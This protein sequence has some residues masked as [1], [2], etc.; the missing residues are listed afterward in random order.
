MSD[1]NFTV[2]ANGWVCVKHAKRDYPVE[3]L[4]PSGVFS[5]Y[6]VRNPN[7]GSCQEVKTCKNGCVFIDK[8]G[9]YQVTIPDAATAGVC[10]GMAM[11]VDIEYIEGAGAPPIEVTPDAAF[12]DLFVSLGDTIVAAIEAQTATL[13]ADLQAICDKLEAGITVNAVQSGEWVVSID[14][15]PLSVELTADNIADLAAALEGLT[16]TIGGQDVTLDVNIVNDTLTVALDADSLAALENITVTID[17]SAGPVEITGEVT[18][19]TGDNG[20]AID[21]TGIKDALTGLVVEAEINNFS[22]LVALLTADDVTITVDGT[23]AIEQDQI[24]SLL[25][26]LT[27]IEDAIKNTVRVDWEPLN[28]CVVDAEGNSVPLTGVFDEIRYDSAGVV[29]SRTLVLSQLAADGSAWSSYT[30]GAGETVAE[31]PKMKTK[32]DCVESQEWTY[33]GDNTGTDFSDTATYVMNLSDGSTL[34]VVQTPTNGWTEQNQL[35]TT[36]WQAEADAAGLA[37]FIEPRA[38]NNAIPTDISGGYGANSVPTGLPGAPSIPVAEYLIKNGIVARYLNFQICPGQPVPVSIV[39]TTSALGLPT[40]YKLTTA[41]AIKGPLQR[42]FVCRDCGEKPIWFLKD[43]VTPASAGQ[44]P[45]CYEPCGVISQLPAPPE[46]D[47]KFEISIG[48]DNNNSTNTVDFT[49]TIT[50]RATICNGNTIAVDYFQADPNDQS[51][52][53]AYTLV[54]DFVDCATGDA[55]P[56]PVLPCANFELTS[57]LYTMVGD[58]ELNGELRNREWHDTQPASAL[59][60]DPDIATQVGRDFYA[61]HDFGLTPDTVNTSTN[62]VLDDTNNT[63]VELDIQVKDGLVEV[64]NGGWFRY[65]GASEGYWAVYLDQCCTGKYQ[66]IADSGGFAPDRTME[67][68]LPKGM[69]GLELVNIDSGGSNSSAS[70]WYSTDNRATWINDNTPPTDI[71]AFGSKKLEEKCIAVK[72]CE[73]SGEAFDINTG[74]A[75]DLSKT[76]PCPRLTC[77]NTSSGSGGSVTDITPNPDQTHVIVNGTDINVPAGLKSVTINNVNGTTTV[78]GVFQL[79]NG[80]RV[81]SITYNATEIDRARGLLPAITLAGG[82]WQWTGLQPIAEV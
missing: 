65:S 54:G 44:I 13:S 53:I 3:Y 42:F 33:A 71:I 43:G 74:Q 25:D 60:S 19:D 15:E 66:R 14:G 16:V 28:F 73:D 22:D 23:V 82:S 51:A 2:V 57:P 46:N 38:V 32:T 50:R 75:V 45:K 21:W 24:D 11:P 52:L 1:Y 10:G 62:L 78:N 35:L 72:I 49:N 58:T 80:R 41:G 77:E 56:L 67:F 59:I 8:P 39:R 18:I 36:L 55:I 27:S 20:L 61:N 79:G 4:D 17:T 40:P 69:H 12:G 64:K 31:C 7:N 37:W 26:G 68:Y 81:D 76:Y 63:A 47:C 29:I 34:S 6:V 30:L 48:C 5:P 70:F 9:K